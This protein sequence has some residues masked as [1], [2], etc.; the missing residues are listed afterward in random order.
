MNRQVKRE[1]LMRVRER[2][3]KGTKEEKG[4]IL[5]EMTLVLGCTRKWAIKLLAAE[6]PPP[7]AGKGRPR[8]YPAEILVPILYEL[9]T[10]MNRVH[11]RRLKAALPLWIDHLRDPRITPQVKDWL[12]GMSPA[13]MDRLLQHGRRKR[14][15]CGTRPSKRFLKSIPIQPKDWNITK[16]GTVQ[17]DTVAHTTSSLEGDFAN[18]VTVT[19]IH[20][21]WTEN[22]AVWTKSHRH[23]ISALSEIED[24]LPFPLETFKSDSGSEFMNWAVVGYYQRRQKPVQ[25]VRGRPYRKNDNC[26]VEQKNFTHVRELFGYEKI[27]R[28]ELVEWMNRIYRD[29]WNPLH[30]FFLPSQ[31]L[32]R[33]NR[34]GSQIKKEYDDPRTPCERVLESPDISEESKN[35]LRSRQKSLNPVELSDQLEEEL[36]AFQA[37][38]RSIR[39]WTA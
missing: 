10:R 2:Y 18:T 23:M 16:P 37:T 20:S 28:I 34:I 30:N 8:R 35:Y 9:W 15:I 17:S 14:G 3:Q 7:Q 13:T 5:D 21:S 38:L 19:D 1:Y 22:R 27:D 24:A 29:L 11:A 39:K 12:L 36:K 4:R 25:V 26:Y 32:L 33:K 6:I 31:K